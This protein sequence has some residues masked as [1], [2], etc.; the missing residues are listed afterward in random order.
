MIEAMVE[1]RAATAYVYEAAWA[2]GDA[3]DDTDNFVA[4]AEAICRDVD[5]GLDW[6]ERRIHILAAR[7]GGWQW[8]H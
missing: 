4:R 8:H 1:P 6:L 2:L 3:A 7:E 5:S